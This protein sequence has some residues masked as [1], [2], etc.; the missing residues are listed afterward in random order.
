[1]SVRETT[2]SP[3]LKEEV[4]QLMLQFWE[5]YDNGTIHFDEIPLPPFKDAKITKIDID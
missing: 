1:M 3:D 2:T 5:A 4:R